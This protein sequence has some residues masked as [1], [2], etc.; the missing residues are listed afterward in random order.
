MDHLKKGEYISLLD[1]VIVSV[2]YKML[3]PK[4]E[5]EVV[6]D[7]ADHVYENQNEPF[8]YVFLTSQKNNVVSIHKETEIDVNCLPVKCFNIRFVPCY[9][10][11]LLDTNYKTFEEEIYEFIRQLNFN[12][13]RVR[14]AFSLTFVDSTRFIPCNLKMRVF[15]YKVHDLT[16]C[17]CSEDSAKYFGPPIMK[18]QFFQTRMID[19]KISPASAKLCPILSLNNAIEWKKNATD[20]PSWTHDYEPYCIYLVRNENLLIPL[21]YNPFE[22]PIIQLTK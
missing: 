6:I 3:E 21:A 14:N 4:T 20:I 17:G 2:Y 5:G 22:N 1:H 13:P 12:P 19:G 9:I 11:R 15:K 8:K 7:Y 16:N 10:N 18:P